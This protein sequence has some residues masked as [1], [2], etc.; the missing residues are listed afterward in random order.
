MLERL[1][2]IE[3]KVLPMVGPMTIRTA[4]TIIAT[5]TRSKACST[6]PCPF[7]LGTNNIAIFSFPYGLSKKLRPRRLYYILV[8]YPKAIPTVLSGV[9]GKKLI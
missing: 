4:M 9:A 8:K 6:I 2:L 5:K 1:R 7:S 3:L